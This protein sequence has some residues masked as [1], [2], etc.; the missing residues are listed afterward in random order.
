MIGKVQ[1]NGFQER[2]ADSGRVVS[3]RLES[4][5]EVFLWKLYSSLK[6]RRDRYNSSRCPAAFT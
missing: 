1:M 3:E 2:W 5:H 6:S 4:H